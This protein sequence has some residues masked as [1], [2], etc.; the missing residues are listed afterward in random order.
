MKKL[1][2]TGIL[3]MTT[4]L[5]AA[6]SAADWVNIPGEKGREKDRSEKSES[7]EERFRKLG[8]ELDELKAKIGPMVKEAEKEMEQY[9]GEAR[10]KQ[11]EAAARLEELQRLV[12]KK[13]QE[14]SAEMN[15]AIAEFRKEFER[16]GEQPSG[17]R[18]S[19]SQTSI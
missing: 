13:W 8:K 4:A 6:V 1:V 5:P 16:G 7:M 14:F 3:V 17:E 19:T 9:K 15:D 18:P 12:E 2:M 11:K 10:K